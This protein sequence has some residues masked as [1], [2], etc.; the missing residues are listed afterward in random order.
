MQH[1]FP[2]VS[3]PSFPHALPTTAVAVAESI[4]QLSPKVLTYVDGKPVAAQETIVVGQTLEVLDWASHMETAEVTN[5]ITGES[6]RSAI[7]VQS[8]P[9]DSTPVA[10]GT[11]CIYI[12]GR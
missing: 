10:A 9:S 6:A 1:L 8:R 4:T 3:F 5:Q 7:I 2:E 11:T 12:A